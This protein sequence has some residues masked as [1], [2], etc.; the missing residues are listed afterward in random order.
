MK[1]IF[2]ISFVILI[3]SS[4]N[5]GIRLNEAAL[6]DGIELE[7]KS[8]LIFK[9]VISGDFNGDG[10]NDT[11]TEILISS[12]NNSSI[13]ELP[14]LEYDSLVAFIHLQQTKL[15]LK[16]NH[17]NIPE[18]M[19]VNWNDSFGFLW[20]MNEGDLNGD[21]TEEISLVVDWA[22]WSAVNHCF[23]YSLINGKWIELTKFEI[24]E[25]QLYDSQDGESF[26]GFI[27]KNQNGESMINT[28]DEE[29]IEV[30]V[31]L[32]SRL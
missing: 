15:S 23:I 5:K 12:K 25:W 22:D 9:N 13:D 1:V 19:T 17:E 14:E 20:L 32:K 21:G 26:E 28:F 11:L 3:F 27:M 6:S 8:N 24:R 2:S 31:P 7:S 29:A 4:M 10:V 30:Q 16:S 18:L